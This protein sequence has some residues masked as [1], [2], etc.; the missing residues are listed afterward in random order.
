MKPAAVL[1]EGPSKRAKKHEAAE[2]AAGNSE[3]AAGSGQL[4]ASKK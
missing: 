4:A 3:Q 1:I 2:Q